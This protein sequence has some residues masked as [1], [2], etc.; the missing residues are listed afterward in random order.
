MYIPKGTYKKY[1]IDLQITHG[2]IIFSGGSVKNPSLDIL[3]LRTVGDARA[4]VS[5]SGTV[6]SPMVSLYSRP[7]MPDTDI[8]AYIILGH[9]LGKSEKDSKLVFKAANI[10]LSQSESASL[11]DQIKNIAGLDVLEIE[12]ESE[13][14]SRSIVT[15]GKYLTPDLYISYGQSLVEGGE[16]VRLRY[17]LSKRFEIETQSGE[18]SGVDLLSY[19]RTGS[20]KNIWEEIKTIRTKRNHI[21]HA[22]KIASEEETDLA[23]SVA[24]NVIETLFPSVITK[25]GFHLHDGYKICSDCK[26]QYEGT[27]IGKIIKGS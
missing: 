17:R 1:G 13:D 2:R 19:K 22:A 27:P 5:V 23:L 15:I 24:C 3:A 16:V 26:C 21:V 14:V 20:G 6:Q 12:S 8:L 25:M 9:P 11:Q 10:L 4:G 7:S 18:H